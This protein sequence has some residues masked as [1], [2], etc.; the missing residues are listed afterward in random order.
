MVVLKDTPRSQLLVLSLLAKISISINIT[1]NMNYG[2]IFARQAAHTHFC[3]QTGAG[4]ISSL[5]PH[6]IHN[7]FNLSLSQLGPNYEAALPLSLSSS[8][9]LS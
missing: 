7:Q 5:A 1:V 9:C 2:C 3:A 6:Q 4:P 8:L